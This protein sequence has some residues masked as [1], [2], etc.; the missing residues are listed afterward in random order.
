MPERRRSRKINVVCPLFSDRTPIGTIAAEPHE[1]S[2]SLALW[3]GQIVADFN[4]LLI[5]T[6]LDPRSSAK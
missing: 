2:T 1:T 4:E 6:D 5:L 3:F